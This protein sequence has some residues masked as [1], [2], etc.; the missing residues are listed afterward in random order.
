[1][2]DTVFRVSVRAT[3]EPTL[4]AVAQRDPANPVQQQ[5]K[6]HPWTA[7]RDT[8]HGIVFLLAFG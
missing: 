7:R 8:C 5:L 6:T 4:L 2:D 3:A 1:M